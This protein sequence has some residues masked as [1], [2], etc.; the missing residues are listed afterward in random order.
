MSRSVG[1]E[2]GGASAS[3]LVAVLLPLPLDRAYDYAVPDELAAAIAPG[4]FVRVP[5]GRVERIGVVWGEGEG[6]VE[7]ARLKPVTAVQE[8]PPMT[9]PLRR[10]V[11]WVADYTLAQRGAVLRMAM[12]V[13]GALEPAPVRTAYRLGQGEP[14]RM[15]EARTRVIAVLQDG[16]P[17]TATE[18]EREAGV[19]AG[20]VRGL[21]ALGALEA[22][23]MREV[24][25]FDRPDTHG[26][27]PI[28]SAAQAGAAQSLRSA[29]AAGNFSVTVLD[30]VTGAGK[31]EVYF[32]AIAAAL[33]AGHQVL[34]L[35]PEIALSAQWLARFRARFGTA[36]AV[37]HSELGT[38]RRRETWRAV[39]EG[40]A[41]VVVGARSALWLPFRPL[42]L[43]VVDEEHD[44][45]FKQE[46]GVVY[47]ARDMA[48]VRARL[49]GCPAVLVSAT[50]SLETVVNV[51]RSR[52]G[53][54]QLPDRHG[55]ARLPAIETVDLR[56]TPP[57]RGTWL[58]P[59]LRSALAE[60]L[61]AGEQALLFLN[62]RG[63]APLTLCRACGHRFHCPN[64]SA[65]LVEHRFSGTLDCHHCGFRVAQPEACPACGEEGSFAACGPGVERLA[66]EVDGA[67]P[68]ARWAVLTSDTVQRPSQ[69]QDLVD[70][71]AARE[72][73]V[74][75]GTQMVAKGHHFPQLTLVGV[76]D[77]DL[78][79]A[80]G[81]MRAAE[82]T[83]QL[84]HQVGGRAGRGGRP[85]RVVLQTYAAE[86]PVIAALA[87]GDRDSF[88]AREAA[89]R[90]AHGLPP[91]GRL[92]AVI[93][94]GP[95]ETETQRAASA[96][97]R[98]ARAEEKSLGIQVLG[99][100]PAPLRLLRGR[101]RFRLLFK[102]PRGA[103]L[104]PHMRRWLAALDRRTR[105]R[106]QVDIDPH[107]FM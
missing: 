28:L 7:P 72:I 73:D 30:G 8:A 25:T 60:T 42:G 106:L 2:G 31:T 14:P 55:G 44:T 38:R 100:A 86:H 70:A 98:A 96:L 3:S 90:E 9:E 92:V 76:V 74:L 89:A 47:H 19:S 83:Y 32:E 99:P 6:D 67:F 24:A 85:G 33:D 53:S 64:C 71:I 68:G 101:H 13:P 91:F 107:S 16:P 61:D 26:A 80:G 34:V 75:I 1:G 102:A 36:P 5:L 65:W 50:P 51:E 103:L 40:R 104:Q 11:D 20:V 15:T 37:W 27:G 52:Y 77:A 35:L 21:E 22:V 41:R 97:A 79:L 93:A 23:T 87:A 46:D 63:Y 12:S 88:M 17:R 59:A 49:E 66:E 58:A 95:G 48:V 10:L 78:G 45:A 82:R 84:L 39:A 56:E 62:R 18:I 105:A 4:S 43:I 94:S 54:V 81:D 69:V 29:A 57:E